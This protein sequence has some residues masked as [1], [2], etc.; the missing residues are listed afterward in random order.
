MDGAYLFEPYVG[1]FY[2]KSS[3][4]L[5]RKVLILGAS[6]YCDGC[7]G[8]RKVTDFGEKTP[9][10]GCDGRFTKCV[11]ADYLDPTKKV[12]RK[13]KSY[14]WKAT[15]SKFY[16]AM[17]D[18]RPVDRAVLVKSIAFYN[19]LQ[20]IEG[21][22]PDDKHPEKF[23]LSEF[24]DFNEKCFVKLMREIQPDVI[25]VWGS[26]V[27]NNFPI[28]R[29]DKWMKADKKFGGR[30][31]KAEFEER[32]VSVCFCVHPSGRF[33]RAEHADVFNKLELFK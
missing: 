2:G 6:H 9:C 27:R 19:Y 14:T 8:E 30:L 26:N 3:S 4:C 31:C 7:T 28:D 16:N 21:V 33:R 32:P 12:D 23:W 15:H 24:K 10:S 25:L 29:F 20:W 17:L 22:S 11:V 5:S 1:E 13:K 18:H